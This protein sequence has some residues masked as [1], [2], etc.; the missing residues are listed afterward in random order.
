MKSLKLLVTLSLCLIAIFM[1]SVSIWIFQ[2]GYK[3]SLILSLPLSCLPLLAIMVIYAP[4]KKQESNQGNLQ[5]HVVSVSESEIPQKKQ[6]NAEPTF[7]PINPAINNQPDSDKHPP[8]TIA[9]NKHQQ[10]HIKF[11]PRPAEYLKTNSHQAVSPVFSLLELEAQKQHTVSKSVPQRV[12]LQRHKEKLNRLKSE[13]TSALLKVNS[14]ASSASTASTVELF[15]LFSTKKSISLWSTYESVS[16]KNNIQ[17]AQHA[18]TQ[19]SKK[20]TEFE[21]KNIGQSND[22]LD[23]YTDLDFSPTIDVLSFVNFGSLNSISQNLYQVTSE[24]ESCLE[25]IERQIESIEDRI[26][27]FD[28]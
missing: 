9:K 12:A 14:A 1:L 26:D 27:E 10:S 6:T 7:T 11:Q 22:W 8:T 20:L 2:H 23:L 18:L 21:R 3:P 24:L 17:I 5:N 25:Q 19:L 28:N 4:Q 15:D 16:A 13:V